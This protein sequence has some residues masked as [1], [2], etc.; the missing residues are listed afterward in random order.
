[1][2]I[3]ITQLE[4]MLAVTVDG[5]SIPNVY[6]YKV[7]SSAHGGTELELKIITKD[8]VKEFVSST[9]IAKNPQ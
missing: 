3:T 4:G 5:F 1:M 7:I 9:R 2:E 8:S 6:D